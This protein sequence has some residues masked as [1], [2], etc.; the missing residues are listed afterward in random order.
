MPPTLEVLSGKAAG[1]SLDLEGRGGEVLLGTRRTAALVVKDPWVSFSHAVISQRDGA[2]VIADKQSRAGTFVNGRK[3]GA[4]GLPL[5][6]G[7]TI[8]LGKTEI[9]FSDAGGPRPK[10]AAGAS[11][12]AGASAPAADSPFEKAAAP[13]AD[14]DGGVSVAHL[15]QLRADKAQLER[16]IASLRKAI[17]ARER[18]LAES[19]QRVRE[20]TR[21]RRDAPSPAAEPAAAEPAAADAAEVE[22]LRG[23]EAKARIRVEELTR[24]VQR[25]EARLR[26][27][28]AGDT[29]RLEAELSQL[30][31][32][33]RQLQE[34][35]R[36]RIEALAAEKAAAAEAAEEARAEAAEA[37]RSAD[38]LGQRLA[39]LEAAQAEAEDA[40]AEAEDAQ[41]A[42]E[43][44]V[45]ELKGADQRR[46]E[47]PALEE[48]IAE[49]NR[50]LKTTR[51][52]R[53]QLR[54]RQGRVEQEGAAVGDAP[55]P[56]PPPAPAPAGAGLEE[57]LAARADD[58]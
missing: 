24:T 18:S 37:Q 29:I 10:P 52:E 43:A 53:D 34:E 28:G 50:E 49:L 21:E 27:G 45:A 6:S 9:R 32:S 25:L 2:W 51:R 41:R 56:A 4:A 33:Y 46:E 31:A 8:G 3:V 30:R 42:A 39:D 35:G 44:K 38:Q 1:A 40:Q 23:V 12:P 15:R 54:K 14:D 58:L 16:T 11:R 13:E 7:D 5:A 48:A 26:Q 55:P 20:L 17:G 22:R 19:E 57:E 36:Q 47:I